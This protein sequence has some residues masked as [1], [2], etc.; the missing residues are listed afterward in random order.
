MQIKFKKLSENAILPKYGRDGDAGLDL[1]VTSIVYTTSKTI[2][3]GF[4]LAIEIPVGYVGLLFP[5]S[6][7]E[8]YGLILSN[9]IGVIDSNYRGEIMA[10]FKYLSSGNQYD[11][12]DKAVQLIILPYPIINPIFVD[13]LSETNRGEKG[14]GS[15]GK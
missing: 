6:S 2:K 12:G 15:S 11:I 9:S 3:Y 4:D 5:R 8:K 7:I 1:V 10:T 14:F 13:E